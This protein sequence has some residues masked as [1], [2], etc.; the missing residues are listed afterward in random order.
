M[1][2]V[3]LHPPD[4]T[5]AAYGLGQLD[6]SVAADVARHLEACPACRRRVA[7]LPADSFLGR[8]RDAAGGKADT[9]RPNES[10]P[11]GPAATPLPPELA[12][13]AQYADIRELG[14]GGMGVVYLARNTIMDRLE[15][16]KVV[17]RSADRFV[18]EIQAAARLKHPNVVGAYSAQRIGGILVFA[19]EYVPGEDLAQ[20]V[21]ARGPLPIAHACN[22]A[23]QAALGL[24]HAHESGMVHRDIK[25]SNLILA[26]DGNKPVVKILDF[27]LAKGTSETGIDASQTA[28]GAMLGTPDYIAPEQTI[29]AAR[30]DIRSDIYSLG[31]TLYHLLSGRPPFAGRSL[32][33]ILRAH[34]SA[35]AVRLSTLRP[36]VPDELAGVVAK[37]MAK[38]PA[39]RFPT[40]AAAAAALTP[41]FKPGTRS[42]SPAPSVTP[43][44]RLEPDPRPPATPPPL[45]APKQVPIEEIGSPP[46]PATRPAAD[47]RRACRVASWTAGLVAAALLVVGT[48]GVIVKTRNGTIVLEGLPADAEVL[49]DG[50]RVTVKRN[51]D[52]AT[53]R[54]SRG[55]PHGL[56]VKL[57]DRELRTSDAVVTVDGE[58]V[59]ITVKD[60][61]PTPEPVPIPPSGGADTPKP[62]PSDPVVPA[63]ST[64][65]LGDLFA[66][67]TVWRGVRIPERGQ[68]A[69]N[70]GYYELQVKTR[71]G[72][73]FT[74][75]VFDNGHNRN[76]CD[77]TGTIRGEAIE[78]TESPHFD[79]D[80]IAKMRG[81]RAG[82]VIR[83]SYTC[84]K[85]GE[86]INEGRGVLYRVP[87]PGEPKP[88][89]FVPIFD[90]RS[91]AGW[92]THS[93]QQGGWSVLH[94]DKGNWYGKIVG[95][96]DKPAAPP[97]P[98]KHLYTRRADYADVHVQARLR[99]T[100]GCLAG[101][102]VRTGFGPTAGRDLPDGFQVLLSGGAEGAVTGDLIPSIN[103]KAGPKVAAARPG[104]AAKQWFDLD[105]I[106]SGP[107]VRVLVNGQETARTEPP[108]ARRDGR[109][110][111][112]LG[113]PGDVE[114]ASIAVKEL[115]PA[116]TFRLP[117][118]AERPRFGE[119]AVADNELVQPR[120]VSG[121]RLVF[122]DK[123]WTD[124]DFSVEAQMTD[125]DCGFGMLFRDSGQGLHAHP[126][127]QT[128]RH[129]DHMIFVVGG[130]ANSAH[131][132]EH[133]IDAKDLEWVAR[134]PLSV[135]KR[136]KKG[137]WYTARVSVRGGRVR[138]YLNGNQL[139]D[140]ETKAAPAGFV[141]LMTWSAPFRFRNIRVTDPAGKV[142][143]E[144]LPDLTGAGKAAA[145]TGGLDGFVPLFN[146][147][148]LTGWM[149]GQIR[150]ASGHN[151]GTKE[152]TAWSVRDGVLTGRTTSWTGLRSERDDYSDFHLRVEALVDGVG[153]QVLFRFPPKGEPGPFSAYL[154]TTGQWQTGSLIRK[155]LPFIECPWWSLKEVGPA[156]AP[157]KVWCTMEVVAVGDRIVVRVDGKVTADYR[158][159]DGQRSGAIMLLADNGPGVKFRK[160]E[161]REWRAAGGDPL[162]TALAEAEKAVALGPADANAHFR[163]GNARYARGDRD[164][165]IA[166]FQQ[167]LGLNPSL[168][169]AH[170]NLGKAVF[171]KADLAAAADHFRKSIDLDP[172]KP[173]AH[174][175][176]GN[177][178][179]NRGDPDGATVKYRDALRLDPKYGAAHLGLGNVALN[180]KDADRA[181]AEYREAIDLDPKLSMA[182]N[183]LAWLLAV[184]PGRVRRGSEA[185]E[186]AT[187]ACELTS[188]KNPVFLDTLA[189]A[190]AEAGDFDKAIEHQEKALADPA[191]DT[192]HGAAARQRLES[193]RR[194]KPYRDPTWGM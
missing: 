9:S 51:G 1:A 69:G 188:W 48:A 140:A 33:E 90:G 50:E 77:V 17:T 62:T 65:P 5:L 131:Y 88:N 168:A 173:M 47:R 45:P 186:H 174:Y 7:D 2:P 146:G 113:E 49:V 133:G 89:D 139:F 121:A 177:V 128:E 110:A 24:Q 109:I 28:E 10:V 156:A 23:Y 87:R 38:D 125:G 31:C 122:G 190:C 6:D 144:G 104:P 67:G 73:S 100:E 136:L 15:V 162:D 102:C 194:K 183:Q 191:F 187:R 35:E 43:P 130:L 80:R 13:A 11:D 85:N 30:A 134:T 184:G 97:T 138:C 175:N 161:I 153:G 74:G 179:L 149:K 58:P 94:D 53:I 63:V 36:E 70:S 157:A 108:T 20:L 119:W 132:L 42:K 54:V 114:V 172:N 118:D 61:E 40:P 178:F 83:V 152:L 107:T 41:F 60:Y 154:A 105:V 82:T 192:A 68:F 39:R 98:A 159:T 46:P 120:A 76:P 117:A 92:E 181:L 106:A 129:K 79:R 170:N 14:R 99:V 59:R 37:M 22:Y 91:L 151:S 71:D 19:M 165:A 180:K 81:T 112:Y 111:L 123:A 163:L 25:P 66:V 155:T 137:E 72:E 127:D 182:C 8:L 126:Q 86:F 189:A 26:R 160:V 64:A 167:A 150:D 185:V 21:K 176:L 142:L 78:W 166:S 158:Q 52:G 95:H 141:G 56:L 3:A 124:Y 29:D 27:G 93:S 164:G 135:D 147:K 16:L 145:A 193:Y 75:L 101:L 4:D 12:A 18:R 84:H 32:Y 169:G 115:P 55:G 34:H 143:L 44:A 57:G 171:E 148:D 103:G 96:L 116:A